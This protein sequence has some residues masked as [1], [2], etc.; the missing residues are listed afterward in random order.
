MVSANIELLKKLRNET[1]ASIADCRA[2]LEETE[3]DYKK[4]QEWLKKRGLEKAEKKGDRETAQGLVESYVHQNGKV[5]AMVEILCE[6]DFVARTDE[7]KHLAHEIAMQVS[8][9][10]PKNAEEL[11]KQDYIRDSSLKIDDLVKQTIAKLGEN[12][13][14]KKI[15][16]LE[17]SE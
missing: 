17:I 8:A 3:N 6:T 7:F 2:A 15:S 12:I 5:G 10:N 4:A 11:L 16:R 14:V 13:V 1:S 9:M